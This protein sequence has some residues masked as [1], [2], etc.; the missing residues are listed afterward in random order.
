MKN[1]TKKTALMLS[2][3]S[4]LFMGSTLA[5]RSIRDYNIEAQQRR[6][7]HISWWDFRPE[8][9]Y[10]LGAQLNPYYT[11]VWGWGDFSGDR[12]RYKNGADIRPLRV[13]GEQSQRE[14]SLMTM[15]LVSD[16]YKKQS[17]KVGSEAIKDLLHNTGGILSAA[18]PMWLLYYKKT[19]RDVD[20]YSLSKFTNRL[21]SQQKSYLSETKI[22]RWFDEEMLKLS[23]RLGGAKSANMDRGARII[24]YHR[25]LL[26]YE[27]VLGRWNHQVSWAEK[28]TK[29]RDQNAAISDVK[30]IADMN[31]DDYGK[32]DLDIMREIIKREKRLK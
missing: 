20:G 30:N 24:N 22:I 29:L 16:D 28:F 13:G 18:D 23:E 19:L 7:T 27:K 12:K 4:V 25:I 5:Q 17:D 14:A 21:T 10:F 6:D 2:F 11:A 32:S 8:P 26:D 31:W 15:A 1:R 3:C 9:K